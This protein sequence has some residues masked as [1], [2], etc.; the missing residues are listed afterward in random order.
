MLPDTQN[1]P[2]GVMESAVR[3]SVALPVAAHLLDPIGGIRVGSRT[4][5]LWAAVP[6]A[7]V[8]E[9]RDLRRS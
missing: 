4:A 1:E 6:E 9:D 5:V 7:A 8:N 2:A 3:V